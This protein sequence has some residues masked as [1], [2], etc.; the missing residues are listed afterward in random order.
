MSGESKALIEK[1]NKVSITDF[2]NLQINVIFDYMPI[3]SKGSTDFT[4]DFINKIVK[5]EKNTNSFNFSVRDKPEHILENNITKPQLETLLPELNKKIEIEELI[6]AELKQINE[7]DIDD[8]RGGNR[9]TKRQK[10]TPHKRN[11]HHTARKHT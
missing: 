6:A 10:K 9:I 7:N 1:F 3:S 2:N 5:N 11:K 8:N 4:Q